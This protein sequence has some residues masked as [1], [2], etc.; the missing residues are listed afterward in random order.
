MKERVCKNCGGRIYKVVGQNM[1]K[2]MFCGTLYVDEQASKEETVLI[3][4]ANQLLRQLKFEEAINEFDKII[5]IYP[6]S[7]ESY[8]GKAL[9]KNKIVL[10]AN[11]RGIVNSPKF[12]SKPST[13]KNDSDFIK[14]IDLAPAEVKKTYGN[15]VRKIEKTVEQYS[16]LTE[17]TDVF[18]LA[19]EAQN[20]NNISKMVQLIKKK[21]KTFVFDKQKKEEEV[22]KALETAK[23]FV[24]YVDSKKDLKAQDQKSIYDRYIYF[25]AEKQKS[26]SSLIVVLDGVNEDVLPKEICLNSQPLNAQ[27]ISFF[28]DILQKIEKE[29]SKT[30][31][32]KARIEK[33]SLEE[34]KPKPVSHVDVHSV[35]LVEL[36]NYDV[37]NTSLSD[38]NKI[39]WIFL[40]LKN[41]DF[42]SA[43]EF[44]D[45]QVKKDPNNSK[46]LFAQL[47]IDKKIKTD[48]EFFSNV[49]NF[50][51]REKIDKI[52]KYANKDFSEKFVNKWQQ[53]IIDL[54]NEDYYETYLLYLAKFNTLNR[55]KLIDAAE[56]KAVETLDAELIEKVLKCFDNNDTSKFV[57]FYFALAQKSDDKD[58]YKKILELDQSHEQSNLMLA[59]QKFKT[60]EAILNYRNREEIEEIFKFLSK[61]SRA[62]FVASVIDMILPI[63]FYDIEKA[64][65]QIDFYLSYVSSD[66]ILVALIKKIASKLLSMDFFKPAEKYLSIAISK[67][68]AAE[69]YWELIKA[70]SHCRTD[71]DLILTN[72]KVTKFAEWESLLSFASEEQTE[73][74]A[75]IVSKINLY[76][77]ERKPIKFEMLDKVGL[78]EKM[79]EFVNRNK[80]ILL[81]AEKQEFSCQINYFL[82]QLE[83]FE[84]YLRNISSIKSFDEYVAFLRK[85]DTRLQALDLSLEKSVNVLHLEKR[86]EVKKIKGK[87]PVSNAQKVLSDLKRTTSIKRFCFIFLELC[88]LLF[89]SGLLG[90]LIG[91]PEETLFYFDKTFFAV[92]AIISVFYAITNLVTFL[93]KKRKTK[94][95]F[96][97]SYL[98]IAVLGIVNVV[99]YF[100]S[101][102]ILH[103][104]K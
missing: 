18:V 96:L 104:W 41:G 23:V 30:Y 15:I 102:I 89:I 45:E 71:Q 8:F 36:G 62:H 32:E 55:D 39:R 56:R 93:V 88:P 57:N 40:S 84:K 47:M 77:G 6:K 13:L 53:L 59:L 9:A 66:E 63:A 67:V 85:M 22:F 2:C 61:E 58:Y 38:E 79:G 68:Q 17:S 25:I 98:S 74:Y 34:V 43:Q 27:A 97:M 28:E 52:L 72:V 83:P 1:V 82:K 70:K 87:E 3:V 31:R 16:L 10:Y 54:D 90:F 19:D 26:K 20:N 7:Y 60:D 35:E 100:V 91:M 29:K 46:L 12:F 48:D 21:N 49:S 14:A 75:K 64:C 92:C 5:S 51:D 95:K 94:A 44:V 80:K 86:N 101:V 81:E 76:K 99:L 11:T 4:N 69:F 103:L 50:N 73:Y 78:T 33:I 65:A 37:K 24:F 42:D